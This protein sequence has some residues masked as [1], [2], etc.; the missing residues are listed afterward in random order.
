MKIHQNNPLYKQTQRKKKKH[1]HQNPTPIH[2]KRK[3]KIRKSRSISKHIKSNIQ[4]TS[5][6]LQTKWRET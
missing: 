6:Q 1:D 3:G 5:S 4:Q 2:D